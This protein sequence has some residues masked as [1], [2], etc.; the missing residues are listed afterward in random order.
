[1]YFEADFYVFMLHI[2]TTFFIV[3]YNYNFF[4]TSIHPKLSYIS[5][6]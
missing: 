3:M 5:F 4:A 1:M 6:K 2:F